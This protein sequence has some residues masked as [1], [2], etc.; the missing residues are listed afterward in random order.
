MQNHLK[1]FLI[2]FAF[3]VCENISGVDGYL[4]D[5]YSMMGSSSVSSLIYEKK[6]DEI[7][8]MRIY[9]L[10]QRIAQ[11]KH[12]YMEFFNEQLEKLE[13]SIINL[14]SSEKKTIVQLISNT[15]TSIDRFNRK[16]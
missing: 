2:I 9:E 6:Q 15:K 13:N 3:I 10:T 16:K 12:D 8:K 11:L 5:P 14:C 7:S 4:L 1:V